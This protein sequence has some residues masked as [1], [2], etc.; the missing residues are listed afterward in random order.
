MTH[1]RRITTIA[2]ASAILSLGLIAP[3]QAQSRFGGDGDE[4]PVHIGGNE[5]DHLRI[6]VHGHCPPIIGCLISL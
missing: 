6:H 5:A 3:A 4:D 2:A 1:F